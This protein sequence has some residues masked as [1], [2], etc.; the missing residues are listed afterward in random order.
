MVLFVVVI[1]LIVAVVIIVNRIVKQKQARK[2][3]VILE[4]DE[5]GVEMGSPL[6]V[7]FRAIEDT[8]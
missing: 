1:L 5:S 3:R 8:F 6:C 7:I 4:C 2:L